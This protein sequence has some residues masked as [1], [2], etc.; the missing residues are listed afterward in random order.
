MQRT[1]AD[2]VAL[3]T[4]LTAFLLPGVGLYSSAVV[5]ATVP[6]G[7]SCAPA[8][9]AASTPAWSWR[10]T[11]LVCP[12][13]TTSATTTRKIAIRTPVSSNTWPLSS[14]TRR[15][16]ADDVPPRAMLPL[17]VGLREAGKGIAR[18]PPFG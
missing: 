4:V 8:S 14:E 17:I 7:S 18:H 2:V 5:R 13:S 10:W 16:G 11:S 6:S 9:A 15:R 3:S 12:M 1:S